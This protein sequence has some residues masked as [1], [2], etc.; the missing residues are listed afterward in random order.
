[1]KA[2]NH[3][4][5]AFSPCIRSDKYR[6]PATLARSFAVNTAQKTH[7]FTR[8][9]T[10]LGALKNEQ[11]KPTTNPRNARRPNYFRAKYVVENKAEIHAILGYGG[12]VA[13]FP[14][15]PSA[16][17]V[18]GRRPR[19]PGRRDQAPRQAV[20]PPTEENPI[21]QGQGCLRKIINNKTNPFCRKCLMCEKIEEGVPVRE[22]PLPNV[23]PHPQGGFSPVSLRLR[24]HMPSLTLRT[25]L[26]FFTQIDGLCK[27]SPSIGDINIYIRQAR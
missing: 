27:S 16:D 18:S 10:K 3:K 11:T 19:R 9:M 26:H 15:G 8:E 12:E 25:S 14:R 21:F 4:T 5:S 13:C 23:V 17:S 2:R 7:N 6:R 1:M 20:P 22:A 24:F